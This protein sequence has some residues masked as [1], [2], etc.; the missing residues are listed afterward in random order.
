[1]SFCVRL[2]QRSC[3]RDDLRGVP[4]VGRTMPRKREEH[5][6]FGR[7]CFFSELTEPNS[8]SVYLFLFFFV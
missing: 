2:G 8:V 7:R 5:C 4:R 3:W 6:F 1:M